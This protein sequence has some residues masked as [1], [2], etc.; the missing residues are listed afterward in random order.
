MYLFTLVK[1]LKNY[2]MSEENTSSAEQPVVEPVSNDFKPWGM[3]TNQFCM[4]M[5]LS[6]FASFIVPFGG[7]IMPIVMWSTNK[8]Q[9]DLVNEHGKNILN[10]IISSFIYLFVSFI[11][12]FV[13]IG[14]VTL[15]ATA[16]CSLIF[17]IIGAVK[18]NN[19]QV[20][21]YPL[22]IQFIK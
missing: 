12:T 8:E 19:G 21:K 1:N 20:Y 15:I 7:I 5:H 13:L 3:E 9:S 10:W 2:I 16:V 4:L 17:T 14:I 18:A 6:Q 22:S 11:L